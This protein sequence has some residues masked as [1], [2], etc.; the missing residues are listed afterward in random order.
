MS[1]STRLSWVLGVALAA[2][3]ALHAQTTTSP[4]QVATWRQF[5][6]AAVSYT[7]DDN[8][9]NQLPVAIP[10]FDQYGFKTTLFTVTN[11]G[12]NWAGLR[13]ASANGHEVTSHTVTHPS[14]G[15]LTI[16]QQVAELQN[17]QTTIKANVPTAKCETVAYPNCVLGDVPT[18]QASYIAGRICSGQIM[19][20][21]PTDFYNLSSIITG[22]TGS[23]QL[24]ADFNTR[25]TSAKT[26]GGWCV[27]LTHGINADGG[28]SPTQS[29]ELAAHLAYM[30]ANRADYWVGTF[31]DVV[32]YIKERNA[33]VLTE[34]TVSATQY[35]LAVTDNLPD[36]VYNAPITVRRLL[37]ATWPSAAVTQ[38]GVAVASTISTVSGVKYVVFDVVPDQGTVQLTSATA[39]ASTS[40]KATAAVSLWPN[41][42]VDALTVALPGQFDV[43]IYSL[44]GKL[45][46]TSHGTTTLQVGR[47]LAAGT[48]VVKVSQEGQPV[49]SQLINKK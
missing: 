42:F 33:A 38:G 5:K 34:T 19:P 16:A 28:Y 25:V 13:T 45:V 47:G 20:S 6:T 35:S 44:T 29:T 26:S 36:A 4:Y 22:N 32:K 46:G 12:P 1:L 10:L 15:T 43:A 21:T 31:S 39:L 24:A 9:S 48:Y 14:L 49:S 18:I 23:V 3:L 30:D 17:S 41:P 27:F 7:L 8:T 11:W 40:A 2:P 37:P